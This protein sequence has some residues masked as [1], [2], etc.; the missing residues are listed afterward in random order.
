MQS[1]FM[2]AYLQFIR[3]NMAGLGFGFLAVFFGNFG[4]SFFLAWFGSDIQQTL[5]LSA[6]DYGLAY[7]LATLGSALSLLW[8]GGLIDRVSVAKY[9]AGITI[10]LAASAIFMSQV[11]GVVGLV[12]GFYGLRLCGQGL[13][14][15]TGQTI[16]VKHFSKSRGKALGIAISGVPVG[17]VILPVFVV[18]LISQ[19]G[20]QDSWLFI[21]CA[22]PLL[23]LPAALTLLSRMKAVPDEKSSEASATTRVLAD[24]EEVV[25]VGRREMLADGRFWCLLPAILAPPY[26]ITGIFI[27]QGALLE[28]KS[29]SA[30][31][32]ATCFIFYGITH[33]LGSLLAGGLVDRFSAKRLICF[34]LL[35][36]L[37]GFTLLMLFSGRYIAPLFM[38]CLGVSMGASGPIIGSLW[39]ELYGT[40]Y[41]GS[42]RSLITAIVVFS[43]SL[44]PVM[45]GFW[46]DG[47]GSMQGII[48]LICLGFVL[49]IL[50][51]SYGS[52]LS[53][54]KSGNREK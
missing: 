21:G 3:H 43:S 35:P 38:I 27:H 18:W 12:C 10:G 2:S 17:E 23:F 29:W 33:W 25:S 51:A 52:F 8:L 41:M 11:S 4:Q 37:V 50:L 40:I 22:I 28:A 24:E 20:W 5:G 16:M 19:Y 13:L 42:I 54:K 46:L 30:S 14:P 26:V 44:S 15:H 49:A 36:M 6:G 48:R 31:W 32:F 53:L 7:S 47:G 45:F 39:A 34:Y 1:C 9:V